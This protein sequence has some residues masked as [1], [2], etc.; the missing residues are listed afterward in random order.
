MLIR[1]SLSDG[2]Y[3]FYRAH[4][5][6]PVPLVQLVR[7]AGT[8][9]KIEEGFAGSKELAALDEHPRPSPTS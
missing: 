5:P 4:A 7:V 9:W 3:A 2:E 8:Q 1:R 6:R